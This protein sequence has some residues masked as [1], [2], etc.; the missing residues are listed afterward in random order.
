MPAR[1]PRRQ[2]AER[3]RQ[4]RRRPRR[5]DLRPFRHAQCRRHRAAPCATARD[6]PISTPPDLSSE[7]DI[8]A[9]SRSSRRFPAPS[10]AGPRR[11]SR[12]QERGRHGRRRRC[13]RPD[14]GDEVLQRGEGR[15]SPA[16]S[17]SSS[18][19]TKSRSWPASRS[20]VEIS[21]D[22]MA[23]TQRSSSPIAARSPCAS[24]A[25]RG[26]LA[27]GPCRSTA[28]A[29]AEFACREAGRRGGRTSARRMP[30]NPISTSTRSS[31]PRARPGADAV[32][33]GYGFLAENAGFADA[34]EAAGLI[35]VGPHG[36]CHP[37]HGRQGR[38]RA[39]RRK[40]RA[41]RWCP[42]R[43]GAHR[44]SRSGARGRRRRPSAFR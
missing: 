23:I 18:S 34:V 29:D 28:T 36:R 13:D 8:M 25:R 7:D 40:R 24:S 31:T 10:T 5:R 26:S 42:A 12:L 11:T 4:G 16:R 19:R 9:T 2:G 27:S 15:Q 33:P 35:F 43:D 44:R 21:A 6:S 37:A 22:A 41:S 30:Q 38:R 39:R 20:R 14:R 1:H 3:R 17:S 32:H